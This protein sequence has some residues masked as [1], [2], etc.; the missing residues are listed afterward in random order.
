MTF[1]ILD[2]TGD[3]VKTFD[4]TTNEGLEKAAEAFQQF[5][6]GGYQ[7]V[8]IDREGGKFMAGTFDKSAVEYVVGPRLGGG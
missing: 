6:R 5:Q 8:G 2:K 3:T 1:R 4:I 7:L